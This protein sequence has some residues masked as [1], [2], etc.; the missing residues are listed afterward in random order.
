MT[1]RLA[2]IVQKLSKLSNKE[3]DRAAELLEK[4]ISSPEELPDL[5]SLIGK[6]KGLFSNPREA[7][8]YIRSERDAWD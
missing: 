5:S 1:Q 3:Q 4:Y 6:S 7:D 2:A 8:Q